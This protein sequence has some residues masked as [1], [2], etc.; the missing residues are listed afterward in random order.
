MHLFYINTLVRHYYC[1]HT[2]D[3]EIIFLMDTNSEKVE[4]QDND[5]PIEM[6]N[7]YPY[8]IKQTL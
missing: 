7:T 3:F 5:D 4:I 2:K 8:T 6:T 1:V